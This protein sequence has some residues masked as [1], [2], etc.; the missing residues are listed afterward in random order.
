[1]TDNELTWKL[2]ERIEELAA[3]AK[4]MASISSGPYATG[5]E[6]MLRAE[7]SEVKAKHG[8]LLHQLEE[9]EEKLAESARQL[10]RSDEI[11]EA[12]RN[13][14][15]DAMIE[16]LKVGV[17]DLNWVDESTVGNWVFYNSG[18]V[19]VTL[20]EAREALGWVRPT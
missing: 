17:N 15:M 7:L 11:I 6:I 10:E 9:A 13:P 20:K 8:I 14:K 16:K 3:G 19:S 2:V 18:S 1:M 5:E 4:Q 12:M